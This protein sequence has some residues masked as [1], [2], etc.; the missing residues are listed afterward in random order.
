M[1]SSTH[2]FNKAPPWSP[3]FT[4]VSPLV[5]ASAQLPFCLSETFGHSCHQFKG[6]MVLMSPHLNAKSQVNKMDIV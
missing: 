2:P 6:D 3:L 5:S 4:P 1:G